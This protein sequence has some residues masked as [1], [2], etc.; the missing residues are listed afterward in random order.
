ME[1]VSY[2]ILSWLD[3]ERC[4]AVI[5]FPNL[6]FYK[7]FTTSCLHKGFHYFMKT[8]TLLTQYLSE[9]N[10][11]SI[12][13]LVFFWGWWVL[14]LTD[15]MASG[16]I[17]SRKIRYGL[18]WFFFFDYIVWQYGRNALTII[19]FVQCAVQSYSS[20]TP[21]TSKCTAEH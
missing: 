11:K 21:P 8:R 18:I 16:E 17:P 3:W 7:D 1:L 14:E 12:F 15:S 10:V 19:L 13:R 6:T 5:I 20:L 4:V 2:E 9:D